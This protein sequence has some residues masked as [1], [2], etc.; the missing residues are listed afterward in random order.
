MGIINLTLWN[1]WGL[2]LICQN[3]MVQVCGLEYFL[4]YVNTWMP[5]L[6]HDR[7]LG[8]P[9]FLKHTYCNLLI[10]RR[11]WKNI[12]WTLQSVLCLLM[13]CFRFC[14][15]TGLLLE[16]VKSYNRGFMHMLMNHKFNI[17]TK[18]RHSMTTFLGMLSST[19][20][21]LH[22][23]IIVVQFNSKYSTSIYDNI[24]TEL[25]S[26]FDS[27]WPSDGIWQHRSG[28]ILVQVMVVVWR[29]QAIT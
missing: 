1:P 2:L 23:I 25:C 15:D 3:A 20:I 21:V 6:V 16:T 27:L 7:P 8:E 17:N 18:W 14:V 12:C 13:T 28:S 22:I 19:S 9:A 11:T 29:P 26:C 10:T 24:T 5:I 4:F